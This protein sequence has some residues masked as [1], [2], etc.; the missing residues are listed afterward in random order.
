MCF[1][2]SM[3][4][5]PRCFAGVDMCEMMGLSQNH[6]HFRPFPDMMSGTTLPQIPSYPQKFTLPRQN[7]LFMLP[8]PA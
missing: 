6:C 3:T 5:Y 1:M 8:T 2:P 4:A 7:S